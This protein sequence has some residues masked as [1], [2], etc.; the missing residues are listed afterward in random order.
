MDDKILFSKIL[1]THLPWFVKQVIVNDKEQRIDI[2]VDHE[3][4]IRVRCPVCDKFTSMYDHGPERIFRRLDTCQMQT[5][6][7]VRLPRSNCP[8]H[9]VKQIASEFG[10]NGSTMTFAFESHVINVAKECDIVATA[11]LC[12][13]NWDRCWNVVERSV[14][15]G[16]K[17]KAHKIPAKIG[18]DEKSFARG[19]KYETLVYNID[20]RTVEYVFDGRGQDSLESYYRQFTRNEL[21]QAE[22]IAMDMWDPYIAA[23]KAYVPD[24]AEKIVF[25][26][27]H[28]MR[29]VLDAVDK[30]RKNEHRQLIE[31]GEDLLKGTKYLWLWSNENI[32]EWRQP[33]FK[34]LKAKDLKVCRAWAIKENLRHM[35]NCRYKANMQKYFKRWYFWATHSRLQPIINA[36]KMLKTHIDNIVTYAKHRITNALAEGIN[37]K[38]EKIKRMAC[39]YR[40]HSHYRAA[41]YFHCGGLDLFPKPPVQP[42]I[43]FRTACIQYVGGT[44]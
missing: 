41:I 13:L 21:S 20:G 43:K 9:G 6:I 32:P 22:A 17:R 1:G 36:A 31:K 26:R 5:Y 29:H 37:T 11:R 39:G 18:V 38:I 25:D 8:E 35:W 28:T 7:H 15:R 16:R 19:H 4:D 27:F 40:N 33:E 34:A 10:E 3:P 23:T 30:V 42:S 24:A 12:R 2:Y 14:D 44:H